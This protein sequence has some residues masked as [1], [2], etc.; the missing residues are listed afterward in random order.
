MGILEEK[1]E[2]AITD[3]PIILEDGSLVKNDELKSFY[4]F[5]GEKLNFEEFILENK[6]NTRIADSK[7]LPGLLQINQNIEI[8]NVLKNDCKDVYCYQHYLTFDYIPSIFWK[9]LIAVEDQRY[10]EHFGIDFKSVFRAFVTNIRQHRFVQGGSTISQQLVKNIFLTNEKT[11]SRKLKEVVVSIYIE[12]RYPK[13]KI[14]EAYLNEIYWG[15]LQG[16]RVKGVFAASLFYFGKKPIDITSYE[17]AI[18]ISLLKGPSF[19][20]HLKTQID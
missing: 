13:E 11:F 5:S 18:L 8:K 19:F 16:I 20:H 7:E 1:I 12:N 3:T 6:Q 9:G 17:G 2:N 10:L 4:L 14:L 15:A